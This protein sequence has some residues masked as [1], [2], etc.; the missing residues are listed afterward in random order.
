[1]VGIVV[2][3]CA[4]Q[5]LKADLEKYLVMDTDDYVLPEKADTVAWVGDKPRQ[6]SI[7][8]VTDMSKSGPWYHLTGIVG[9]NYDL[10]KPNSKSHMTFYMV[11]P[12]SYWGMNSAYI[13]VTQVARQMQISLKRL[14]K[15]KPFLLL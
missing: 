7:L 11:Y 13:C 12:R 15:N 3:Y 4:Y 6:D 2:A 10:L 9:N 5:T 14:C 1:M 8:Y